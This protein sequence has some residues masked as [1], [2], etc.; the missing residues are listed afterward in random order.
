MTKYPHQNWN[1]NGPP[2]F[3]KR[4]YYK[5]MTQMEA[6][7][8]QQGRSS[9]THA[10]H[11][12]SLARTPPPIYTAATPSTLQSSHQ[13]QGSVPTTITDPEPV[14]DLEL[15]MQAQTI[16]DGEPNTSNLW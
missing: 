12:A 6:T 10:S 5:K 15:G 16:G 7:A 2:E 3:M 9:S 13:L 8:M 1:N 11:Q 4:R 14:T